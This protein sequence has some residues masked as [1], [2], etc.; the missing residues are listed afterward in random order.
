MA[1]DVPHHVRVWM[2][3]WNPPA[4]RDKNSWAWLLSWGLKGD[5]TV[6]SCLCA[7][8]L[9]SVISK[10]NPMTN[11]LALEAKFLCE[12]QE[13]YFNS[14]TTCLG[15]PSSRLRNQILFMWGSYHQV[16]S[17]GWFLPGGLGLLLR[18]LLWLWP[19][20]ASEQQWIS[21]LQ[22]SGKCPVSKYHT[23]GQWKQTCSRLHIYLYT[24]FSMH[25]SVGA[26]IL[27][28]V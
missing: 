18:H 4:F 1:S 16:V 11:V 25:F 21:T 6:E 24:A 2:S 7:C 27:L 19:I 28:S 26:F 14:N 13:S 20:L 9:C 17:S 22:S 3:L 10:L 23:A 12:K 5:I 15:A 8:D